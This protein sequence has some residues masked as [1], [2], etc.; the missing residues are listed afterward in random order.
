MLRSAGP[1]E[2]NAGI[3]IGPA[4]IHPTEAGAQVSCRELRGAAC[5]DYVAAIK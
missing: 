3:Q 2:W 5:H 4:T 1:W